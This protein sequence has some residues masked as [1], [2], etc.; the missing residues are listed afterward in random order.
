MCTNLLILENNQIMIFPLE[1]FVFGCPLKG[2]PLTA[3]GWVLLSLDM[4]EILEGVHCTGIACA[5]LDRSS[6]G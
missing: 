5:S 6:I 1:R 4:V 2:K 3:A